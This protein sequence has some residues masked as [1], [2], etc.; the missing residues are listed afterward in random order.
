MPG[1]LGTKKKIGL[2]RAVVDEVFNRFS[3]LQYL[4]GFQTT[5]KNYLLVPLGGFGG[6]P[7]FPKGIAK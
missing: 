1:L 4:N 6:L 3:K 5:S 7:W 2:S